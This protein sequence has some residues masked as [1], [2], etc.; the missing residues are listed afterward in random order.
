[1]ARLGEASYLIKKHVSWGHN[2]LFDADFL[3]DKKA[4]QCSTRLCYVVAQRFEKACC[5]IRPLRILV[6]EDEPGDIA[7]LKRAF[8]RSNPKVPVHFVRNGEEVVNTLERSMALEELATHALPSLLLLDLKM[9]QMNGFEVLRWL[10][11]QP[12]LR[13]LLVVVFSSSEDS[14]DMQQAN[15]L[16]ADA[17]VVKPKEAEAFIDVIC[18]MEK[19]WLRRHATPECGEYFEQYERPALIEHHAD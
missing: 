1:M 13:R 5:M 19:H 4:G 7:L 9:P 17:F 14:N 11:N 3:A 15:E 18:D 2:P 12:L 10:Q 6:A 8:A 16:G